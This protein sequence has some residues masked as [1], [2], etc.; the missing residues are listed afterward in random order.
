MNL[1]HRKGLYCSRLRKK[2]L[3][4]GEYVCKKQHDLGQNCHYDYHCKEGLQCLPEI[5]NEFGKPPRDIPNKK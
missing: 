2:G 1:F 5:Y 4:K 3:F